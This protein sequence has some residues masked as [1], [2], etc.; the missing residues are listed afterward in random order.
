MR[1]DKT[2]GC[3]IT[4]TWRRVSP[5]TWNQGA[6][7]RNLSC[8]ILQHTMVLL[9]IITIWSWSESMHYFMPVACQSSCG[10]K[11]HTMLCGW[12]IIPRPKL[13]M[14]ELHLKPLSERSQIS[15]TYVSGAR[16]CGYELR[17]ETSLVAVSEKVNG[18]EL[19]SSWKGWGYTGQTRNLWQPN[20]TF[21]IIE[22]Q[23]LIPRGRL[24]D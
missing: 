15:E 4:S 14:E 23:P 9:S 18:L 16:L 5:C 6:W 11:L 10:E 21:T 19:M 3:S 24:M 8:I 20:E 7:N 1:W 12:W 13:L 2:R 22:Y 17:V